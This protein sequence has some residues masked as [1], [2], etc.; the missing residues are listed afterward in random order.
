MLQGL[1]GHASEV[2]S[3]DIQND[4]NAILVQGETV[5]RAFKIIRDLFVF[6]DKRLILIDK[7]GITGKKAEYHSIPYK[8]ISHFSVETAGTFDMDAELKIYISGNMVPFQ[9]E[10]KKGADI[11][12]VQ[13]TLAEFVLK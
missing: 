13:K 5:V 9:R 10:F 11:K 1:F 12:G 2:N 6:T 8:S 7:Q 3:K 4:L